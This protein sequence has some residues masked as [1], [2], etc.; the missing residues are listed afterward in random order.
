MQYT[1]IQ[2]QSFLGAEE[3]DFQE[4]LPYMDMVAILLI[5]QNHLNKLEIPFQQKAH[6]KADENSEKMTFQHFPHTNAW[7]CKF[8]LA[9]RS[10]V[11]LQSSFEQIW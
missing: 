2:P 5:T 11:H 6:V 10:E 3:K 7:G 8:D 9:V 4:F 1:K